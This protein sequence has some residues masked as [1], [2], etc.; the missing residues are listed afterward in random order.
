[1][2][3]CR[4]LF[5]VHLKCLKTLFINYF[6]MQNLLVEDDEDFSTVRDDLGKETQ[7]Q[8]ALGKKR[9]H[10]GPHAHGSFRWRPPDVGAPRQSALDG[11]WSA[12]FQTALERH[13][14]RGLLVCCPDLFFTSPP[15]RA[16]W[17]P[18]QNTG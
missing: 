14:A 9:Y 16:F 2:A 10:P 3:I 17:E 12:A 5:Y 6:E 8:L 1:M 11:A 4:S 15:N 18:G 7:K 13:A